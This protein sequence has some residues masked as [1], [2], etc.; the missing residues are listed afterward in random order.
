MAT[1]YISYS[2]KDTPSALELSEQLKQLGHK[3]I[4][5]VNTLIPGHDWREALTKG[6]QGA[7]VF[8]ALLTENSQQSQWVISELGV[9]LG[10]SQSSKQTLILPVIFGE[11]PIP[12][13]IQHIHCI[14]ARDKNL[15]RVVEQVHDAANAFSG[16]LAA[17]AKKQDAARKLIEKNASEFINEAVS[18]LGKFETRNRC[19]GI[20]WYIAGFLSLLAGLGI[21][22][23]SITTALET[24]DSSWTNF[25]YIALKN[26]LAIALLGASA[27]YA[28]TLGRSFTNEALK[29]S[30]RLHAI[31]FGKF[32]LQVYG[33]QATWPEVK[34]AFQHWNIDRRS[35]LSDVDPASIDPQVLTI[36]LEAVKSIASLN[37]PSGKS[38]KAI[39]KT[40]PKPTIEA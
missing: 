23:I 4:I 38:K 31:S 32:Y 19:V 16:Q 3:I 33:A 27:K 22:Y 21:A 6:L 10:Y 5:D 40:Q 1:I 39:K 15:R 29:A 26:V 34:E 14:I 2:Q 11:L 18:S 24:G 36:L 8:I 12:A 17:E 25:A 9:A 13:F 37:T 35:S 28:F 7:D 20:A 30:D